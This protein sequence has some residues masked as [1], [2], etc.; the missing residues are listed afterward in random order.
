MTNVIFLDID[1]PMISMGDLAIRPHTCIDRQFDPQKIKMLNLMLELT[2]SFLCI[3]STHN[4]IKREDKFSIVDDLIAA[5]VPPLRFYKIANTSY[6]QVN[7]YDAILETEA[8]VEEPIKWLAID[9]AWFLL[10]DDDRL[11][12]VNN[13]YGIGYPEL[14]NV[15]TFFNVKP[16]LVLM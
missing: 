11:V 7:R 16:P 14:W 6:P 9:D 3:N 12:R 10:E 13:A 4:I 1:G 5:G 8:Q 15:C 2:N